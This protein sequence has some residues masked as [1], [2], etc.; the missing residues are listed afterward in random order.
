VVRLHVEHELVPGQDGRG[1]GRFGGHGL[2]DGEGAAWVR[3][4]PRAVH[5]E[6]RG[7]HAG[8]AAQERATRHAQPPCLPLRLAPRHRLR[9]PRPRMEDGQD[10]AVRDGRQLERQ[11]RRDVGLGLAHVSSNALDVPRASERIV[12]SPMPFWEDLFP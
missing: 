1:G 3:A 10:L 2:G 7:G 12:P 5:R 11:L 8:R 9:E 6:H 4:R